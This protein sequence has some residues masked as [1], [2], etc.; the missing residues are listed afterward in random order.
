[1]PTTVD[2]AEAFKVEGSKPLI[3]CSGDSLTQG[4]FA[5][6]MDAAYPGVMDKMLQK[7]GYNYEGG[8][9]HNTV[10]VVHPKPYW[11]TTHPSCYFL[12]FGCLQL[13]TPVLGAAR[14]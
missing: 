11:A 12:K 14:A 6:S 13:S 8:H 10:L 7:A 4:A 9:F 3:L 1:M 5:S 2:G